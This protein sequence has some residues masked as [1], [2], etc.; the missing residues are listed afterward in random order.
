MS[1]FVRILMLL[2]VVMCVCCGVVTAGVYARDNIGNIMTKNDQNTT[3]K[4]NIKGNHR[5][6]TP[7]STAS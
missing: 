5:I 6:S 7:T 4:T 2:L 3:N 1:A